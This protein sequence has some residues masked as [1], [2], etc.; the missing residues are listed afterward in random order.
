MAMGTVTSRIVL[1]FHG[2][3]AGVGELTWGQQTIWQTMLRTGRT[4][5]IGGTV[6]LPAGSSVE[7]TAAMLRYIVSRHQTL[8]TRLRFVPGGQPRQVVCESG[9]VALEIVDTDPAADPADAAEELRSRYELTPFDH[10]DEWPIRMGVV[11][12]DGA[13]THLV[14]QY[15]HLAVDGGGIAAIV[16]DL[17]HLDPATGQGTAPVAGLTPLELAA[18][19]RTPA[20]LRCSRRALRFWEE[21]V[22]SIPAQRLGT[23]SDPREPR[24]WELICRSPALHLAIRSIA[25]RTRCGPGHVLLGIYAVALARRTGRSPSVAQVL[26]S[27]RFRPG[28]ADS[29]SHLTQPSICAIDVLDTTVDEVVARA[30]K[31]GTRAYLNGYFDTL[32]HHDMLDRLRRERGEFDISCFI[33]DRTGQ[34]GPQPVGPPPTVAQL[35]AAL[36]QTRSWWARRL[37]TF[38]GTLYVSADAAPEAVDITVCADTHRLGPAEIEALALEMEAVA[39]AAAFDPAA[40]TN[41]R[42]GTRAQAQ[43]APG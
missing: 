29:A 33:N 13:P 2:E 23:S 19:Q 17:A 42:A 37:D 31:A 11:R 32:A 9:E 26:V 40:P 20:G 35:R 12:H 3:G 22:R 6:P 38:D 41:V 16:R 18:W 25:H 5:N 7:E 21:V 39:V 24:F 36:P 4:M 34:D 10:A 28:L 27:N 43:P 1:P 14:V 15:C 8:R 30:W